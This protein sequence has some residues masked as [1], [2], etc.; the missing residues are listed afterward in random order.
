MVTNT[1]IPK[2]YKQTDV[3]VIP[4]DW[5]VKSLRSI[6]DYKNGKSFESNI[7][8]DGDYYLITLDSLDI[9]GKLKSEHLKTNV[10]DRS[11]NK[12]DIIMIL[13]DVAHGNFLGLTDVIP[14]DNKYV[15]NQRVGALKNLRDF[16]PYYLS[17]SINLNQKY[18]KK[19][20]Q[21]SSQQNL[22]KDDILNFLVSKPL[23]PEQQKIVSVIN[24]VD[25][26]ITKLDEL[27]EKK[28]NIKQGAMQELLTGKRRLPGFS[29]EWE[30]KKLGDLL[31]YEQPTKYLVSDTEYN[32]NNSVPVLT[33]GKTFILG[34]TDE[35]DGIFNNL[36]TIIFDDFTTASKYVDFPFKAKSSAMKM[37]NPRKPDI[38]LRFVFEKM[39]LIDF[40]L[41]DHKR[42][43]IS[44]FQ[45]IEMEVPEPTEQN[46]IAL[47]LSEM[48]HGIELLEGQ[49]NKYINVKKGM[50]Q[51]LLTGKIRLV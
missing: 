2:G 28:R 5:E 49:R 32:D 41:G 23:I 16:I 7:V 19:I 6:V 47:V 8:N 51:Q 50:M 17:K 20:G 44:E 18:F 45:N 11:L 30:E 12:G 26:F 34:Y 33:A 25:N 43:W 35:D 1:Q 15:L 38:N 22:A 31:A 24:D 29:G 13:S 48:D 27:I 42:Y 37:L 40:T 9:T 46:A 14:E 36:P 39:Q 4:N 10:N 21:G 3:G